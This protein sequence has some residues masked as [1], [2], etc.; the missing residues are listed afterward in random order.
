MSIIDAETF[1]RLA[2]AR[3]P[4]YTSYP[5]APNFSPAFEEGT[6]RAW[7]AALDPAHPLSLYLHIPFCLSLCWYCGCFTK[8]PARFQSVEFY[9][10]ALCAEI[11][12]ITNA[13]PGRMRVRHVHWGGGTP[14]SIGPELFT[15]VT[16]ILRDRFDI[17]FD[18]E[19][20]IEIDPRRLDASLADAL[21]RSG[22]NRASLG[23][24]TFDP[25]VQRA[26]NREQSFEQTRA[27]ADMLRDRGIRQ[28]NIDLVYGLPHQTVTSCVGTIERVLKLEPGRIAVFG[29]AHV[30]T[31][32]RHQRNIDEATLPDET[33]RQDQAGTIADMLSRAGY[34]RV[35]LDHFALP[36]DELA[37]RLRERTLRRNFQG[38]TA[39][40]ADAL[41]GLGASAI[42]A[43]PQGYVQNTPRL[44]DY[45]DHVMSHTLPI[46]RGIAPTSEDRFRRDI[47]ANLMC[48]LRADLDAIAS[49]HN[50][51]PALDLAR[52]RLADLTERGVACWDG[53]CL[54][55]PEQHRALTRLVAATF[56]T[57]LDPA[58]GRHSVAV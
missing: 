49:C 40:Q 24:Q 45:H 15:H 54:I 25:A 34:V 35:G 5:T 22:I 13:L 36:D 38:Y 48:Y 8:I 12:L 21:A 30:P 27:A 31:I 18:S 7:L 9:V 4:R 10:A 28:I 41:I 11:D 51:D 44:G 32:K 55:V 23:V 47:I 17:D 19:H 50:V 53:N 42:G 57:Y 3:V 39:D 16:D 52:G 56:D 6:Y 43:L 26:I 37:R 14:T 20:A 33:E 46:A 1:R 29:Y 2:A 58:E